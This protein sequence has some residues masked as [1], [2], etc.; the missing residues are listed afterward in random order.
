M[1]PRD[2]NDSTPKK[3]APDLVQL[4]RKDPEEFAAFAR[5]HPRAA[6]R[7]FEVLSPEERMRIVAGARGAARRDLILLARDPGA[8]VEALPAV[9]L[10][11]TLKEIGDDAPDLLRLAPMRQV[12]LFIDL[13][14]WRG[15]RIDIDDVEEWMSLLQESGEKLDEAVT[16]L[17]REVLVKWL[18]GRVR[19]WKVEADETLPPEAPD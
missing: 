18:R 15:D 10:L 6:A 3:P 4:P 17:D 14:A 11:L 13:D 12:R 19:V 7:A 9:D 16:G 2:K 8:L 5:L 1:V